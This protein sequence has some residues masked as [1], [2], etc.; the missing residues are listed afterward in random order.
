MIC[1]NNSVCLQQDS[2]LRLDTKLHA[3]RLCP[4]TAAEPTRNQ[5]LWFRVGSDSAFFLDNASGIGGW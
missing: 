3:D 1:G 4:L 5:P 2:G